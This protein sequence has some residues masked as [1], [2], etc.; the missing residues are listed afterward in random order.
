MAG[1]TGI[2]AAGS[3]FSVAEDDFNDEYDTDYLPALAR[4]ATRVRMCV[5]VRLAL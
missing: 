2:R 1:A 4:S 3:N 5:R